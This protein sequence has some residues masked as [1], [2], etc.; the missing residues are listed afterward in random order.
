MPRILLIFAVLA[1]WSLS[2]FG[3]ETGTVSIVG[4]NKVDAD[5]PKTFGLTLILADKTWRE[6]EPGNNFHFF[7]A[8]KGIFF[9]VPD[10]NT[11]F[12]CLENTIADCVRKQKS[13]IGRL[14]I[15]VDTVD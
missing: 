5:D 13:Q 11:F 3:D 15:T 14:T 1:F 6:S 4:R 10:T 2:T 9:Y 12:L 8:K 7:K